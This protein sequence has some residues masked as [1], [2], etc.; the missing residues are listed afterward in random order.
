MYIAFVTNLLFVIGLTF[1]TPLVVY[2]LAKV[3]LATPT[4]LR[5]YRRHAIIVIAV[6]SA[7]LTPTPDPVTMF[8]VMV[9]MILLY[10]LGI[11]LAR[12]A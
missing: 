10:E 1:Q 6:A 2:V 7:V 9:P 5:R 4:R 3:G 8:M 12:F 11:L